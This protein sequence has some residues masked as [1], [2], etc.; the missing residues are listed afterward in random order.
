MVLA[1]LGRRTEAL[2]KADWLKRSNTYRGAIVVARGQEARAYELLAGTSLARLL[3]AQGRTVEARD[4]LEEIYGWFT[5]GFD[6][7]I[8][9]EAKTLVSELET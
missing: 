8:L 6:T 1:A 7:E 5:E 2:S 4:M 3:R 9:K